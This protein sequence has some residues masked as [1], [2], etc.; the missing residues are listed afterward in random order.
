[1]LMLIL[2]CVATRIVIVV[3]I[4]AN[5]HSVTIAVAE[6]AEATR[7]TCLLEQVPNRRPSPILLLLPPLVFASIGIAVAIVLADGG[8]AHDTVHISR[9]TTHTHT[10]R[11]VVLVL[12][13]AKSAAADGGGGA[14]WLLLLL[15]LLLLSVSG[16]LVLVQP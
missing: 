12:A 1:M 7:E 3:A 15:L 13:A 2:V 10:H 4:A 6:T 5:G 9:A 16:R 14:C 11:L 8:E